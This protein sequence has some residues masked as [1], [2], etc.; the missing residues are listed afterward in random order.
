MVGGYEATLY[1]AWPG[2]GFEVG[3]KDG[4]V[5]SFRLFKGLFTS[6]SLYLPDHDVLLLAGGARTDSTLVAAISLY[7]AY[8]EACYRYRM[9]RESLG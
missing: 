5:T 4:L 6:L 1:K 7:E 3:K 2:L 9:Y 8:A